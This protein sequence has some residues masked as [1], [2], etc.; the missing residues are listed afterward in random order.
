MG[1]V[2]YRFTIKEMPV[3]ERPREKLIKYG[4]E[5]LTD[6]ELLALIIRIGNDKRTAIELAQDIINKFGGLKA[7]YYLSIN[8]LKDIK[9]IGD[10]KAAQIKAVVELGKR[11]VSLEREEKDIV[12]T[13]EDVVQLMMPELRFLTQEVFKV[14]LL[15]IKN[16]VI[17]IP[18]I[19]KGGLSSSIVHPREVFKEAIKRSAA[20]MILVHNHPSGIPEPSREDINITKRLLA[21]GEILGIDVLD[22][23]II[24]DGIYYSMREEGMI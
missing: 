4:A 2:E 21:A 6:A 15:D 3:D 1:S 18:L 13:P 23:V 24:G 5:S 7:L 12:R 11:L 22:H 10:A 16:Q 9:G 19:S 17:A 8:E 20:A 14:I